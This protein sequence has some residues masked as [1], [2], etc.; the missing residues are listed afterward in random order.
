[1]SRAKGFIGG[2]DR[3]ALELASSRNEKPSQ[4]PGAKMGH[5]GAPSERVSRT[6]KV[7]PAGRRP[8]PSQT[9]PRAF[10]VYEKSTRHGG[11]LRRTSGL[12]TRRARRACDRCSGGTFSRHPPE[13]H[14]P[15]LGWRGEEKEQGLFSNATITRSP[16][17]VIRRHHSAVR[18]PES[19]GGAFLRLS[20][21]TRRRGLNTASATAMGGFPAACDTSLPF[22]SRCGCLPRRACP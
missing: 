9:Q 21:A 1:M 19:R 18:F 20:A 8:I 22:V 13:A 17:L 2:G 11:Q 6:R 5:P 10:L 15:S 16:M 7:D 4:T 14:H 12:G 3:Q